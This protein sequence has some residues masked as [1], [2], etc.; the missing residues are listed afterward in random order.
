MCYATVD[1]VRNNFDQKTFV[2]RCKDSYTRNCDYTDNAPNPRVKG[3][4]QTTFGV[5]N[6]S[7]LLDIPN[8]DVT[9]QMPHDIMHVLLEGV[10]P[11]E[12]H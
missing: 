3:E 1:V 11:Y 10:V 12:Y 6:R 7:C 4:L 2:P 9:K 8:F 5:I